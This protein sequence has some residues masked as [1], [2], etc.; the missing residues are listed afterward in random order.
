LRS[1]SLEFHV[2][3]LKEWQKLDNSVRAQF[4]KQLE[5]RV[6]YPRVASAKLSG[7]LDN[8]YK[9]KL[10]AVGYRLVYEVID[11]RLIILIVA[12]GKR[13]QDLV[14]QKATKRK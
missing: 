3:A 12:I 11:H 7:D 6:I 8:F 9:I 4:K 1:F 14:Y 5:K 10:K 13:N 2:L